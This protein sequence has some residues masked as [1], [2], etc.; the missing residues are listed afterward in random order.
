MTP[1]KRDALSG[2]E[3]KKKGD[4]KKRKTQSDRGGKKSTNERERERGDDVTP[5]H[6]ERRERTHL[7]TNHPEGYFLLLVVSSQ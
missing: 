2:G 4:T 6:R 7:L 5:L 1:S 3:E